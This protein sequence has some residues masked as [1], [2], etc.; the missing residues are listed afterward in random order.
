VNL[1]QRHADCVGLP[2][3]RL[4]DRDPRQEFD[5]RHRLAIVHPERGPGAVVDRARHRASG[6]G[7]MVEQ[8]E[9]KRQFGNLGA[10]FEHGQDEAPRDA[11]SRAGFNQPVAVRNPLGD[12]L[13]RGQRADP[14]V[15][16]QHGHRLGPDPGIDR[17]GARFVRLRP[18]RP[19]GAAA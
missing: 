19:A 8:A 15:V 4:A 13:G 16:D 18:F 17:H 3:I 12:P 14:E 1:R 6:L 7:Q 9:K 10:A 5:Q 11:I 2:G